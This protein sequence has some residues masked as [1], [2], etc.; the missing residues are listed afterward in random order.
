MYLNISKD[1]HYYIHP[2]VN[3]NRSISI[4]EAARIQSFPDT[5]Y[6][7][8]SRTVAFKQIGNAVPQLMARKIANKLKSKE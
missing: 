8:S 4:R 7:E 6:F 5:Y 1:G 2:D 3:Q